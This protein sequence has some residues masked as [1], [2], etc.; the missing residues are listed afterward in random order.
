MSE[1]TFQFIFWTVLLV[2]WIGAHFYSKSE[3]KIA[4]LRRELY[5]VKLNMPPTEAEKAAR[6]K[7]QAEREA[8]EKAEKEKRRIEDVEY[9]WLAVWH[10][11]EKYGVPIFLPEG[12]TDHEY[13]WRLRGW[14]ETKDLDITPQERV[15]LA[16]LRPPCPPDPSILRVTNSRDYDEWLKNQREAYEKQ[17][18]KLRET[19]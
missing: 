12:T 17:L 4:A 15:T 16:L 7:E 1:S 9:T 11:V 18:E 14:E 8:K 3:E 5:L 19:S 2:L 13:A 10:D 6:A